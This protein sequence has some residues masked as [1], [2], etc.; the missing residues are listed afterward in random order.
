LE[1]YTNNNALPEDFI[2]FYFIFVSREICSFTQTRQIGF[3]SAN[4]GLTTFLVSLFFSDYLAG[5]ERTKMRANTFRWKVLK[6]IKIKI[7][8]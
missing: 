4:H 1:R 2:L 7:K 8:G 5:K 6:I 3:P